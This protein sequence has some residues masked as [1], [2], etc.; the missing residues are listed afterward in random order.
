MAIKFISPKKSVNSAFLKLPVPVEKMEN[1]RL[2]LGNPYSK[3]DYSCYNKSADLYCL[4]VERAYS[5]LKKNGYFSFIMPNK[6]M[7]VDY[8]KELRT[9]MSRTSLKKI[10]NFG[11]VQFFA[12]ATIYV[13]IF[14]SQKSGDKKPVLACSLNSKNYHGEF[15]TQVNTLVYQ[16]YGVTD[17]EEI[18]AVE[19]R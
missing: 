17:T 8:G 18:E 16:L 12:D 10:L 11:D 4:F 6:W 1:F 5:L 15:E 9:F 14:V 2:S 3:R 19:K 13:C 7:L